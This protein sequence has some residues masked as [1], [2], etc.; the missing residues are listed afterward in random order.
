LLEEDNDI[1]YSPINLW[2]IS[3]K[4]ALK[5]LSL[6]GLSPEE[7]YEELNYSFYLCKPIDNL[8]AVT[9][10]KLPL[11]HRDPFD[12]FLI[13]EAMQGNLTLISSDEA[14][15]GYRKYGLKAVL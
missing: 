12:R 1:Y 4:Y 7:F 9:G 15:L 6:H 13:W 5:K 3:I 8:A 14:I 11:F 10:Y 2:E